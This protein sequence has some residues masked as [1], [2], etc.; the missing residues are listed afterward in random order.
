MAGLYTKL[1]FFTPCSWAILKMV[2]MAS[3]KRRS[4][5]RGMRAQADTGW[6][7]PSLIQL[8]ASTDCDWSK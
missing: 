5:H 7:I 6:A 8:A 3:S 4:D 1:A 2:R